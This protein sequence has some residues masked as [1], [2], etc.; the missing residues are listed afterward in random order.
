MDETTVKDLW[1]FQYVTGGEFVRRQYFSAV[2]VADFRIDLSK[3]VAGQ[4]SNLYF[5]AN[6]GPDA[7]PDVLAT[8]AAFKANG[9]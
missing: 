4:K 7:F 2:D 3:N 1:V 5:V 9:V 8:E 6:V